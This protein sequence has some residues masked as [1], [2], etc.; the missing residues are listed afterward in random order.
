MQEFPGFIRIIE[1]VDLIL[2]KDSFDP[3]QSC[4]FLYCRSILAGFMQD[5]TTLVRYRYIIPRPYLES[6]TRRFGPSGLA[7][8]NWKFAPS[9]GKRLEPN[10]PAFVWVGFSHTKFGSDIVAAVGTCCAMRDWLPHM[11]SKPAFT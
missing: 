8:L 4:D 10:M 7:S 6:R 1:S 9:T 2:D 11:L 5:A 3:V